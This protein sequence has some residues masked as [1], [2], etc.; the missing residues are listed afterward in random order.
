MAQI[1]NVDVLGLP[2]PQG[3]KSFKGFSKKG[4]AILL[5]SSMMTVKAW[6]DA[7]A[8][9]AL[10]RRVEMLRGP[11]SMRVTF[12]LPRPKAAAKREHHATP[13]DLSKLVRATED[14]LTRIAYEDDS[15]ICES[16][17]RKRYVREGEEPGA[18]I[19]IV[20]LS[21]TEEAEWL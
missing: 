12:R 7:V 17:G 5:E 10:L 3:S 16:L 1:F 8:K 15:R 4:K 20:P 14:A 13:P 11:V 6:R 18:L 9:T 21:G 19:V 2:A